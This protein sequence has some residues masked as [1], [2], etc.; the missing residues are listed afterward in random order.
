MNTRHFLLAVLFATACADPEV[1]LFGKRDAAVHVQFDLLHRPLPDLPL[2]NDIAMRLTPD[3]PSGRRI[4]VSLVAGTALERLVRGKVDMLDGWGVYMPITIPF[5]GPIDPESVRKAHVGDDY[6]TAN[7]AI[8]VIDVTRGSPDFGKPQPLDLG[9]GNFP[10]VLGNRDLN[11]HSNSDARSDTL[12]IL[13]DETDEDLNHNGKLD[14]GEDTDLDGVL[15]VPNY[16]PGK[17][18]TATD[19]AGR[20]DA[21]MTFYE[22]ETHTL[23]ARPLVPLRE[24]T[25][26]AV[27]VTT[28]VQD[29]KGRAVGSPFAGAHHLEQ[30]EALRPLAELLDTKPAA[31]GGLDRSGVAFAWTFTTGDM[32]RDYKAVRDGLYGFGVQKNL[33]K[34]YPPVV[35]LRRMDLEVDQKAHAGMFVVKGET[36]TAMLSLLNGVFFNFKDNSEE[37]NR[38]FKAQKYVDYHVFG[39]MPSPR[40]FARKGPDGGYLGYDEMTWP[41]DL[42][43]APTSGEAELVPFWLTVPKK[44]VSPRKDGK[45]ASIA[46]I[47]HGYMSSRVDAALFGGFMAEHGLATISIDNVSHGLPLGPKDL[48]QFGDDYGDIAGGLGARGLVTALGDTRAWDQDL[49]GNPDSGADFW[50]AYMFHTRD[51]LRQTAVDYMQLARVLRSFDGKATWDNDCNGDGKGG[52]L[53]GDFD[54]DGVV[55][56]GGPQVK[57]GMTGS[58]L[59]GI[60]AGIMNGLE[61]HISAAVPMCASGGLGDVGVRSQQGG[62][63]EAVLLRVMGPIYVGEPKN[64]GLEIQTVVPHLNH[65]GTITVA[66]AAAAKPGDGVLLTN[67]DNG[68]YDCALVKAD[69]RFQVAVASDVFPDHPQRHRLQFFAGNPFVAGARDEARGKACQLKAGATP[70]QTVDQFDADVSF[71]F[72]SKPL[73]FKKGAPLAPLAE[74]LGL[75]RARPELRR[76]IGL[77]QTI[78]D[79]ADPGVIASAW[80]YGALKYATPEQPNSH[81]VVLTTIGDLAVPV[82]TGAALARAGGLLDFSTKREQ[83]G[84]RTA[85]QVLIDAHV[86]EG[87][88]SLGRYLTPAGEPV[89]ADP[90]DLSDS[91]ALTPGTDWLT[92]P[93]YPFGKDSYSLPRVRTG[94]HKFLIGKDNHGGVS[95]AIFPLVI[96]E[97]KHDLTDPGVHTDKQAEACKQ[98]GG[99]DAKC[100]PKNNA[101][102]DQGSLLRHTIAAFIASGGTDWTMQPCYSTENCPAE[103]MPP[104]P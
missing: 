89:L 3:S 6:A 2:P 98:M 32:M 104:T 37:K 38:L 8:Y 90:E 43:S 19:W 15:D 48:K 86:L 79:P 59:G 7:D 23:I 87:V 84:N 36:F 76:F 63:R 96:P 70:A 5:S 33:N 68:E 24:K 35:S 77:A 85:N 25:T 20:A 30:T 92:P 58:S 46:I 10:I 72:K 75:H 99:D 100:S 54:G 67:L 21:L 97:G 64:G 52:D 26:Y 83:W 51:V 65:T 13:F 14:D 42:A 95:G 60:T 18:P 82:A 41:I 9:A 78:V 40:L 74:G 53:A 91:A 102:F 44:E 69:G 101:Y 49:D 31:L 81:M 12:S 56:I 22:R 45:P 50:T 16:L 4:N 47:G 61:P 88:H 29:E 1:G 73:N 66:H 34:L 80:K 11:G 39:L 93:P 27:V 71:H 103:L 55:D 17:T 62:V 94:L 28:R 57:I